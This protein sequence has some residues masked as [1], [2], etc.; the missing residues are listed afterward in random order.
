MGD[1]S[2][3]SELIEASEELL[4]A[5]AQL[6]AKAANVSDARESSMETENSRLL[7]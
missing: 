5:Y 6:R 4:N 3:W 1:R 2:Q 7:N